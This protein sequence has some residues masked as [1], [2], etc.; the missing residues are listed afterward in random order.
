MF[1]IS[2]MPLYHL[3]G[4]GNNHLGTTY[5]HCISTPIF[6]AIGVVHHCFLKFNL[7]NFEASFVT[8]IRWY[9]A[10]NVVINVCH[11]SLIGSAGGCLFAENTLVHLAVQM[12][13]H[14]IMGAGNI[15]RSPIFY[16]WPLLVGAL[17][18]GINQKAPLSP[19]YI[20]VHV[21]S[22]FSMSSSRQFQQTW[23]P[24]LRVNELEAWQR[25]R[26]SLFIQP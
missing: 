4:G 24:Q 8:S 2:S 26:N 9:W 17:L 12:L 6:A 3:M 1:L 15:H 21:L 11:I 16:F 18:P 10:L 5:C 20:V 22:N 13:D 19:L 23:T 14:M 7:I 25:N